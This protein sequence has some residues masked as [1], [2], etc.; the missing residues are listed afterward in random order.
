MKGRVRWNEANLSEIEANKP[1]RQKITEPKTPYH[2]SMDDGSLS[3]VRDSLENCLDE[4]MH[5]DT[6]HSALSG[7]ASSSGK[8]T[9]VPSGWASS[10]DEHDPMDQD[11]EVGS[12]TEM[13]DGSGLSFKEHRR[14]HYDE[15][16]KVKELMRNGSKLDDEVDE[17]DTNGNSI[18]SKSPPKK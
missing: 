1:E 16:R 9:S 5:G 8:K 3:P 12:E 4:A 11:Y 10:D 2:R 6:K 18:S 7:M 15:Y 13:D 14:A 17:N